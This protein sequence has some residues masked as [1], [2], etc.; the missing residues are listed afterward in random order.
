[1][2]QAHLHFQY[3]DLEHPSDT[4]LDGMWLF[5][6]QEVL[7]FGAL[8]F[9]WMLNRHVHPLGYQRA[10]EQTDLLIGRSI[11]SCSSPAA[12]ST[13]LGSASSG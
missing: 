10:A 12:P 6:A 8:F 4:A 2:S 9:A 3:E 5:L 7:F 1:M 11:P 13:R